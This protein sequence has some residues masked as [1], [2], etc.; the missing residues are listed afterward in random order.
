MAAFHHHAVR[1]GAPRG[2]R[3]SETS[4]APVI[5][6]RSDEDFIAATIEQL[7]DSAGRTALG[8][9]LASARNRARV[10]KLFQ[11]VQRQFHVALLSAWCD[12]PGLPRLDPAR[13]EAAVLVVRRIRRDA[14]GIAYEG[15]MSQ[16]GRLRGWARVDRLGAADADPKPA[17][18]L[19]APGYSASIDRALRQ[20]ALAQAD[21]LLDEATAPLFVA[22]PDVC[23]QAGQSI[24][25]GIVPTTSSEIAAD[26]APEAEAFG[27]SFGADSRDF[28]DHL[29]APLRGAAD[30]WALAGRTL[31]PA[32]FEAIEMPA[33]T[34]PPGMPIDDWNA[35]NA[36]DARAR[37]RR[38]VLL[39][40]QLGGEFDAFGDSPQSLAIHAEL[41]RIA[42]PLVLRP[43]EIVPRRIA[44][45]D[46]LRAASKVLLERDESAPRPEM[47][48]SWPA[49]TDGAARALRAVLSTAMRARFAA[50]NGNPGRYDEPGAQYALRAW[51]RLKPEGEC[52]ARTLWSAY[53]EP[54]V[55][56]P[57]YEGS[58]APPARITLPDPSDRALLRSLKPNVSFV[59]P[60]SLQALLGGNPKDLMEGKGSVGSGL[61]LGWIC[62]F[63]I[64]IITICAFIILNILLVLFNLFFGWLFFIKVCLPFPKKD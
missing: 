10:L 9:Q 43:G 54:F 7:R 11:P 17:Q 12:A 15:W 44:A 64:P 38:F 41:Q 4:T 32:W 36:G 26:P 62:S 20:A 60:P 23:E 30:S 2:L 33:A 22:P 55:I 3:P 58:G 45:G 35:V 63:S 59:V 6:Q 1:L 46:F 47:V 14:R 19:P 61:G 50:I 28:I 37:M 42:L 53:S 48:V 27:D 31:H 52:P 25:Y 40:R 18:R 57:W 13:V 8:G 56:A 5:V 34:P 39:L 51:L 49:L 16:R 29:V 21:A 24:W